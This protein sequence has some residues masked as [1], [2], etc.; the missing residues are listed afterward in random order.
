MKLKTLLEDLAEIEH[1][2]WMQW[3][4]AVKHEVSPER[5]KRWERY[6]VPYSEQSEGGKD[7]DRDWAKKVLIRLIEVYL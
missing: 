2:Q 7:I 4:N 3:A 5:A 6:M 1:E